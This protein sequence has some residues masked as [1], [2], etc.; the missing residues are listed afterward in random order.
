M[1][2]QPP[3][4]RATAAG[5]R[6][7]RRSARPANSGVG[8]IRPVRLVVLIMP[9]RTGD[10]RL[11]AVPAREP[12]APRTRRTPRPPAR[13]DPTRL[14]NASIRS[15]PS[16]PLLR[17]ATT[18]LVGPAPRSTA[19][20]GRPGP[21]RPADSPSPAARPAASR[22]ARRPAGSP[23][24]TPQPGRTAITLP[25]AR[26]AESSP[27][28]T[29]R[30]S[31]SAASAA[32]TCS[33]VAD[34]GAPVRPETCQARASSS[35]PA[36]PAW[37]AWLR[38]T[39]TTSPPRSC[40]SRALAQHRVVT[41]RGGQGHA[42]HLAD[43]QLGGQG[44]AGPCH[45]V[46]PAPHQPGP[47]RWLH[48]SPVTVQPRTRTVRPRTAPRAPSST[49]AT[50]R[51]RPT[52]AQPQAEPARR[53]SRPGPGVVDEAADVAPAAAFGSSPTTGSA[54]LG[55][56]TPHHTASAAQSRQ[57]SAIIGRAAV[58]AAARQDRVRPGRRR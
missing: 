49:T 10:D 25:V 42:R 24:P 33:K 38:Q 7:G 11:V 20:R 34:I 26:G 19:R 45:L 13:V 56:D 2:R 46:L 17:H 51:Q 30:R 28:T 53:P 54:G 44:R 29:A 27:A 57:S 40:A 58:P 48:S 6:P 21:R 4:L 8:S 39:R 36:D 1:R 5:A 47:V 41:R 3:L 22:W 50:R 12:P 37:R 55:G 15:P 9:V 18:P 43:P 31:C 52:R 23:S 14:S 16:S 32:A 35:R